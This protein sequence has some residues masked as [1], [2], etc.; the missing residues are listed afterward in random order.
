MRARPRAAACPAWWRHARARPALASCARHRPPSR[1]PRRQLAL[2]DLLQQLLDQRHTLGG[3]AALEG[4]C[5]LAEA[6]QRL[7]GRARE[8]LGGLVETALPEAQLTE[9]SECLACR[10]RP[11]GIELTRRGGQLL[12]GLAPRSAPD[13]DAGKLGPADCRHGA[14]APALG[15]FQRPRAP[16]RGPVEVTDALARE[17]LP[18][19]DLAD[20]VH[21]LDLPRGRGGRGFI[22][23]PHPA[24]H[25]AG[26]D[27]GKSFERQPGELESSVA[28][29]AAQR[30]G[31][32]RALACGG[33][34]V[35]AE[36][37][38]FPFAQQQQAV[39]RSGFVAFEDAAGPL[40][41]PRRDGRVAAEGEVVPHQPQ[42]HASRAARVVGVA[43]EPVRALARVERAGCVVQPPRREAELLQR[44]RGFR[45]GEALLE[46]GAGFFP[47]TATERRA[48]SF[49]QSGRGVFQ[50]LVMIKSGAPSNL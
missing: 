34:V 17:D 11:H 1:G 35:A 20:G 19:A 7:A 13:Q 15:E 9:P 48:P 25:V 21:L 46:L 16:L 27:Q 37:G 24:R 39:L 33:G 49:D 44:G 45:V 14:H 30:R 8:Q 6:R 3:I 43:I 40:Q 47:R 36:Q 50:S 29:R 4:Q 22:Q 26:A 12:L 32:R 10:R 23:F 18:A 41:P 31:A 5:G 42:R 28:E 38:D 2:P